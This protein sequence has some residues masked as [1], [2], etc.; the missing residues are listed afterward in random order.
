MT[1]QQ[2]EYIVAVDTHRNFGVAAE[3]CFVTQPTL[4]MM[5]QKLEDELGVRIFDRSKYRVAP[6]P[7]GELVIAQ[8]RKTLREAANV[9]EL[10][11]Q[12]RSQVAGDVRLGIIP[13][14]APYLLPLFLQSFLQ[15]YPQVNIRL[16]EYTTD[17]MIEKIRQGLLD[18]AL[19]VTPLEADDIAEFPLFYEPFY[20][21]TSSEAYGQQY[22]TA[23]DIQPEELWL[24]EE[25]HCFRTQIL[26]LCELRRQSSA[27]I[28]Y[29]AGSIETLKHLVES[30]HGT[31]ILPE[32]AT[33]NLV[34][35]QRAMLREFAPP[36][37]MREVS[38][39]THQNFVRNALRDAFIQCISQSLPPHIRL[40]TPQQVVSPRA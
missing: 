9:R 17:A 25:G 10:V 36:A 18:I 3:H 21:Y 16:Y 38:I 33:Q 1:L 4:S 35:A 34:P 15:Q 31:T 29:A 26:R 8:A 14:L 23:D 6:T 20:V 5:I 32:L 12:E 40:H 30:G 37:P 19:V 13:T 39:V 2:L 24:L 22:L 28:E 7:L 11:R 27:Q